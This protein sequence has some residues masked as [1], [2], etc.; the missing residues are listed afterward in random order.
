L[1]FTSPE[2]DFPFTVIVTLVIKSSRRYSI[3]FVFQK[4]LPIK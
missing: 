2:T 3:S 4:F 1:P